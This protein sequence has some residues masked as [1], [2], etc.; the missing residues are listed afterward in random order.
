M[1][2]GKGAPCRGHSACKCF[3]SSC[4][5]ANEIRCPDRWAHSRPFNDS[6]LPHSHPAPRWRLRHPKPPLLSPRGTTRH[7][8]THCS[9]PSSS[10]EANRGASHLLFAAGPPARL[11]GTSMGHPGRS[12]A[13]GETNS[14]SPSV[15]GAD[16]GSMALRAPGRTNGN[17]LLRPG[18]LPHLCPRPLWVLRTCLPTPATT[19][20]A[21]AQTCFMDWRCGL[22]KWGAEEWAAEIKEGASG[23]V[24]LPSCFPSTL[25]PHSLSSP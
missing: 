13:A 2:L 11:S 15:G 20:A 24:S 23:W 3:C 1:L 6:S 18:A 12:V 21:P 5:R 16:K 14:L 19:R 8:L 25:P 22:G 7:P 9:P 4:P 10:H 17:G